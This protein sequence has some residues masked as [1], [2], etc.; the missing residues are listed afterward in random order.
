MAET[1][2]KKL[3][4]AGL[5]VLWGLVKDLVSGLNIPTKLTDLT[6]DGN[7]VQD[8]NYVHSDQNFTSALKDKLDGIAA[9]A[10]VNVV[11]TIK[12]NNVALTPTEKAVNIPVPTDNSQIGNSAG[13]QTAQQVAD[14]IDSKLQAYIK[15]KGSI[16]FANL[17]TPSSTNLG[18]MWNMSDAFTIDS[19][20]EEYEQ[21]VTKTYP[22]GTNVYVIESTPASGG[23]PAVY[24]FDIYSG[25]IDLSNYAT[26]DDVDTLTTAEIQAICV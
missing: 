3:N 6:N 1:N 5:S 24:K 7:F 17:P 8:G 4:G 20:F 13:Y 9:G 22:K 26:L 21:G 16:A 12:V 18:W 11:E 15:P 25:F 23:T 10:Q 14:A 19:R 2:D